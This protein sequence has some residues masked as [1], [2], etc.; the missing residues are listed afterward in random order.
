MISPTLQVDA[1][2]REILQGFA[3][4]LPY[5]NREGGF[6][7][8]QSVAW[9]WHPELEFAYIA[10]GACTFHTP[11]KDLFA[12]AGSMVFINSSV[13]HSATP[14]END[15]TG[16]Y[17]THLINRS[18]LAGNSGE[19]IDAR[20][21]A[22]VLNCPELPGAVIHPD[23]DAH[24]RMLT[25]AEEAY[26]LA[27]EGAF[28]YEVRVREKLTEMWLL[29]IS[30]TREI[31]ENAPRKN[32]VRNDRIRTMLSYIQENCA[33][34]LTLADI[35]ASAGISQRECLRCFQTLLKT[36]P[37]EYLIDCRV[38]KAAS[39]LAE[40]S[41][42]IT[43]IALSCGFGSASYFCRLFRRVMHTTPSEYKKL[44]VCK[45]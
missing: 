41:A 3:Q 16:Y 27:D 30:E 36:T 26:A 40:T 37:F 10:A 24:R 6:F 18:F 17:H 42:S 1:N 44:H 5:S 13:F 2:N 9:H 28:L 7:N 14:Y 8:Q 32:D 45:T 19:I 39:M 33:E 35:A 34:K 21:F 12:P 15:Q 25:L 20:Y 43:D 38:R 29:F 4:G 23:S 11:T 22:P 31:W